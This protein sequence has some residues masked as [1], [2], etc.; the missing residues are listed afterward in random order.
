MNAER[1]RLFQLELVL[2]DIGATTLAFLLAHA[3]RGYLFVTWF[4]GHLSPRELS[5]DLSRGGGH[6]SGVVYLD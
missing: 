5:V 2:L 3:V 4:W 6:A 1:T